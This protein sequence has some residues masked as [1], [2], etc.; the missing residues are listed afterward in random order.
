MIYQ[1]QK[2]GFSASEYALAFWYPGAQHGGPLAA[3]AVHHILEQPT[4]TEM[5]LSRLNMNIMKPVSCDPITVTTSI[6]RQ[7]KNIQVVDVKFWQNANLVVSATG[8]KYRV[9]WRE[10]TYDPLPFG[11]IRKALIMQSSSHPFC[12]RCC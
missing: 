7:G 11:Q 2:D 4:K 10:C 5:K 8:L 6:L 9:C 3:L 1:R 12:Q